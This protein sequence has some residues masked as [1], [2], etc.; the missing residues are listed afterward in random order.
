MSEKFILSRTGFEPAPFRT[1]TLLQRLRPLG[2]HVILMLQIRITALLKSDLKCM[3]AS[4]AES[5]GARGIRIP[6]ACLPVL[7]GMIPASAICERL[8]MGSAEI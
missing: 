7:I 5:R 3:E 1:G 8:S 2:H 6:F 4:I